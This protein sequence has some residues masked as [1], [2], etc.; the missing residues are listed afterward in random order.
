VWQ[1]I[2]LIVSKP[3][4][5]P[6]VGMVA[7]VAFYTIAAIRMGIKNDRLRRQHDTSSSA[8]PEGQQ[9]AASSNGQGGEV[10]DIFYQGEEMHLPKR[11][12]TFPFLVRVE[13]LAA[14]IV[15]VI[16]MV[17]SITLDAPLEEPANPNFTPNPSKAPWYFLGLQELLVYFDPWIA[18][19]VLPTLIIIGLMAIPYLDSQPDKGNGYYTWRERRFPIL[20]F[21]FGFLGLW[22]IMVI[23]G[24]F[25]RGPGWMWF[26]PGQ[27]WDPHRVVSETNV[28]LNQF[29][30]LHGPFWAFAVGALAIGGYFFLTMTGTYLYALKRN[31]PDLKLGIVRFSVKYL[32]FWM[33]MAVPVKMLLRLLLHIKY[34]MVTPWFNV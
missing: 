25:M 34:V 33:M 8:S 3:D 31:L 13:F 27:R 16:L 6:I 2:W 5:V 32:L 28:D 9:A 12:H 15:I 7:L 18:G 22:V 1:N 14:L 20:A 11:V 30:G 21:L 24:T 4:N 10:V 17:W 26:W 23:I 29:L 19:V